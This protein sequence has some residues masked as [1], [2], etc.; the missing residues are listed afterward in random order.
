MQTFDKQDRFPKNGSLVA[1][2]AAE[3]LSAYLEKSPIVQA[4]IRDL[5]ILLKDAN[6]P[7]GERT[8]AE[9][10][11][12][13]ALFRHRSPE[14]RKS[15]ERVSTDEKKKPAGLREAHERMDEEERV[16]AESL[17]R[18]LEKRKVSQAELARRVGVQ[19]SAI[20]MMLSRRCRPQRRTVEKIAQALGVEVLELWPG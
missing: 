14:R 12:Q 13:D 1:A 9:T 11:L 4:V 19:S 18:L 20:S 7:L 5:V 3:V 8:W 16:F 10:A 17:A 2:S 6:L 15:G